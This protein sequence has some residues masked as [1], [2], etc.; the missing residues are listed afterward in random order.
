MGTRNLTAVVLD[1]DFKIAQ[2]GQWDGYPSGQG[3]TALAF[4]HAMNR[5]VFETKLRAAR[6]ATQADCERINAELSA[7]KMGDN[8]MGEGGKY[9]QLS[10]DRGA[11]ILQIVQDAEPGIVLLDRRNFA[12][13][14]LFCEWA[15]VID[16]D[17]NRFEVY[18]GFNK[19][20][21]SV[22][23]RFS[24]MV[25]EDAAPG[26]YPVSLLK[27]YDLAALPSEKVFLRDL[28]SRDDVAEAA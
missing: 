4:L 8:L 11:N 19:N 13:D 25:A 15:Y 28:E 24:A 21:E 5:P 12:A 16:L 22:A 7:Q 6:F 14:S 18:R 10:R 9:Q 3:A 17:K 26:Y 27:V 20:P 1:G 23:A 2:Y